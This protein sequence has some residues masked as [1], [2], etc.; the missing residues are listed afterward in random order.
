MNYNFPQW[1]PMW[2]S[3]TTY[4]PQSPQTWCG[5]PI[6]NG[7]TGAQGYPVAPG[8]SVMLMDA[9]DAVFYVKSQD[10]IRTFDFKE[11][12]QEKA[13]QPQYVTKDEMVEYIKEALK[14]EADESTLST[15]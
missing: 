13:E 6:V 7:I 11:R 4:Y 3:Q 8:G 12:A 2:Q 5:I 10:G 1:Q 14:G 9:N 15:E